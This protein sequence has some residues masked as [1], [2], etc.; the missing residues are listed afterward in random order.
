M[1]YMLAGEPQETTIYITL[2]IIFLLDIAIQFLLTKPKP[3]QQNYLTH[4]G[5][6]IP[7][8]LT[9][10]LYLSHAI[11]YQQIW[12]TL[13]TA[14]LAILISAIIYSHKTKEKTENK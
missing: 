11:Y 6:K 14:L 13:T 2:A 5:N 9:A 1:P 4:L 7:K 8:I 12:L 10:A 3:K